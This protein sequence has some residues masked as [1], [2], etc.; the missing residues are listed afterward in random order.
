VCSQ[1][2]NIQ[3]LKP[4]VLKVLALC[5]V[6]VFS[7]RLFGQSITGYVFDEDSRNPI[8]GATVRAGKQ[9]VN[10]SETG[11][12]SFANVNNGDTIRISHISYMTY[13]LVPDG[14]STAKVFLKKYPRAL[15]S[16]V[17][18]APRNSKIDSINIRKSFSAVFNYKRPGLKDVFIEKNINQY[19]RPETP[20]Q[21][22]NSLISINLLELAALLSS[23]KSS[24]SD[25]RK[26]LLSDEE[27]RYVASRFSKEKIAFITKLKGDSLE[28]FIGRYKPSVNSMKQM[29]EYDLIAFIR[30]SYAH[31]LKMNGGGLQSPLLLPVRQ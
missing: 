6:L 21:S 5:A 19:R 25:L 22:F 28:N 31:F 3:L 8:Y 12:F 10:T 1:I 9:L 13:S 14:K 16:V 2:S 4:V 18:I 20:A 7:E 30:R 29:T 24:Q 27:D 23:N 15:N 17:I 26:T 11:Y